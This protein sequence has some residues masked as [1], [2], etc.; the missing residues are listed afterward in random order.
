MPSNKNNDLVSLSDADLKTILA[1]A[2][3]ATPGPWNATLIT[4]SANNLFIDDDEPYE[5]GEVRQHI[6]DC[7]R[8]DCQPLIAETSVPDSTFIAL[9]SPDRITLLVRELQAERLKSLEALTKRPSD[10]LALWSLAKSRLDAGETREAV[11]ASMGIMRTA[12]PN[13]EDTVL[14]VMDCLTDWAM[15]DW[16][17]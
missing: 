2:R 1:A 11:L 10:F 3:K 5:T 12:L 17:L 13:I 16:E 15:G 4:G 8:H 14:D 6:E 9:C 7:P